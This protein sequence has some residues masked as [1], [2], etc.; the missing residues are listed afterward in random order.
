MDIGRCFN[1]AFEVYKKN[2]VVLVVAVL[3]LDVLDEPLR[4]IR[5]WSFTGKVAIGPAVLFTGL[6]V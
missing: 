4:H 5:Q 6:M 2:M 3:L 1:D